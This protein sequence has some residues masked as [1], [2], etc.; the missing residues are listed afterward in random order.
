MKFPPKVCALVGLLLLS[1]TCGAGEFIGL[2]NANLQNPGN[3]MQGNLE[4][5]STKR[6]IVTP[7]GHPDCKGLR[8]TPNVYT[9]LEE[10]TTFVAAMEPIV[11][12][13]GVPA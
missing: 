6:I 1:S 12:K 3:L 13:G 7:I 5:W 2:K 4:L 11:E 8:I 9:T 10:V